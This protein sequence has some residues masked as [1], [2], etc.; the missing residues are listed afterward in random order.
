MSPYRKLFDALYLVQCAR[1]DLAESL[2]RETPDREREET[3]RRLAILKAA[4]DHYY[5]SVNQPP[6]LTTEEIERLEGVLV[7]AYADS[8]C[9]EWIDWPERSEERATPAGRR[10]P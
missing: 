9:G 5:E 10:S 6:P 3:E 2:T 4:V 1:R 8:G 7:K